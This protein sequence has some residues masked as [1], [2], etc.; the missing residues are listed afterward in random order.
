MTGAHHDRNV[1]RADAREFLDLAARIGV[2]TDIE[3]HPLADANTA[4]ARLA[5]G[6]V[7]GTAVLIAG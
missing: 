4:L 2:T 3:T 7:A 6:Q 1:T 5:A